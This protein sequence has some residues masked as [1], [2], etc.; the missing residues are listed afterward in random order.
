M[1]GHRRGGGLPKQRRGEW[2]GGAYEEGQDAAPDECQRTSESLVQVSGVSQRAV[3]GER[4]SREG[5]PRSSRTAGAVSK[6]RRSSAEGS[7]AVS[8]RSNPA[9]SLRARAGPA[10]RRRVGRGPRARPEGSPDRAD[11]LVRRGPGSVPQSARRSPES[12]TTPA[13]RRPSRARAGRSSGPPPTSGGCRA[14]RGDRGARSRKRSPIVPPE[15]AA[16]GSRREESSI[17]DSSGESRTA[18][19]GTRD[20]DLAPRERS[21]RSRDRERSARDH[22]FRTR[23]REPSF[24][25]AAG[26]ASRDVPAFGR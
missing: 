5:P 25:R 20:S 1:Q 7:S 14:V 24:L 17:P 9:E 16:L 23:A 12:S 15:T 8:E 3:I 18:L 19:R 21:L 26:P 10:E 4:V 11:T 13:T 6:P 22:R 2:G